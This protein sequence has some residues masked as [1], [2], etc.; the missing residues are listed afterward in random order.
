Y[1]AAASAPSKL[2][3]R[4]W[5]MPVR[6]VAP[7]GGNLRQALLFLVFLALGTAACGSARALTLAEA[8]ALLIANNRELAA[9]RRAVESAQAQSLIAGA[10]PNATFSVNTASIP[11]NPRDPGIGPGSFDQKRL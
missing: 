10:R 4:V 1:C 7:S 9:A 6:I 5:T 8:E 3:A 2:S 11:I